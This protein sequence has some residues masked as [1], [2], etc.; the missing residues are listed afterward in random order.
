[1][2]GPIKTVL[3][4][5]GLAGLAVTLLAGCQSSLPSHYDGAEKQ[6]KNEVQMVRLAHLVKTGTDGLSNT[7]KNELIYF[8]A[9]MDAGYGD[10]VTLV[11]GTA[12]P[13]K[14][15]KDVERIIRA[16]GLSLDMP[17]AEIG[18][19]PSDDG[20]VLVLD[21]YIVTAP[22][23][24]G[25][26]LNSARNPVNAASPQMGC[27]NII[28]LGQMVASPRDLLRGNGT[29]SP[30]VEKAVQSIR[31]WREDVPVI[32]VPGKTGSSS[33]SGGGFGGQ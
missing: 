24:P 17:T 3:F 21:R 12:F 23:C 20:A 19:E 11:R 27:A 31:A 30:S 4:H 28:N 13:D 9:E 18:Y 2:P 15:A 1:M 29:G 25:T 32:L 7:D 8:L 10:T 16:H 5:L 22:H 33:G 14:A 26:S 6:A